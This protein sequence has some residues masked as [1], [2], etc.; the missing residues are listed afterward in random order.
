[1]LHELLAVIGG[2]HDERVVGDAERLQALQE[3]SEVVIVVADLP[4]VQRLRR[5]DPPR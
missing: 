4:V 1:V 2:D 5:R 3:L